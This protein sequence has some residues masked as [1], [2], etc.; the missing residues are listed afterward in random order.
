MEANM[1]LSLTIKDSENP[2]ELDLSGRLTIFE[3]NFRPKIAQLL[4]A[5]HSQLV[6]NMSNVTFIDSCG[7]AQ[8]VSAYSLVKNSRGNIRV[9]D[10]SPRVREMLKITKLDSVFG[11]DWVQDRGVGQ[12]SVTATHLV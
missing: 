7:L 12:S 9:K 1:S 5:G 6:L 2:L 8:L 4:K 11:I 10:P 3:E